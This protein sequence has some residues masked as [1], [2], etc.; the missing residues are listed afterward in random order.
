MIHSQLTALFALFAAI[1]ASI[2]AE[3]PLPAF[4]TSLRLPNLTNEV[5]RLRVGKIEQ[6][7]A[8][9][10]FFHVGILPTVRLRQVELS[11]ETGRG[12]THLEDVFSK[13]K[14]M[15]I[16]K[17][18][19]LAH[20]TIECIE[21]PFFRVE[22]TSIEKLKAN[23]ITFGGPVILVTSGATNRFSRA[24]MRCDGGKW[25]VSGPPSSAHPDDIKSVLLQ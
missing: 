3:R 23:R 18:V 17:Q 9:R 24:E 14:E 12:L 5:I 25:L 15:G 6:G 22:A 10:G 11:F 20:T 16:G 1:G 21:K 8:K 2:A 13:T 19:E 7:F 4:A